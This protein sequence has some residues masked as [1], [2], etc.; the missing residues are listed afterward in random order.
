MVRVGDFCIDRYEAHTVEL[1]KDGTWT[2]HPHYLPV[3]DI[4]VM[5]KTARGVFPQGYINQ[6]QADRACLEAGKR[7]CT[8]DEWTK[9][10]MGPENLTFTYGK[11]E[12]PGKC[13][14]RKEHLL[15]T[16]HGIDEKKWTFQ[17]FN[18]PALTTMP[19]FL[20]RSGT[21]KLCVSGFGA[22]D[23]VGNLAEWTSDRVYSTADTVPLKEGFKSKHMTQAGNGIF[24]GSFYANSNENGPGCYYK[25]TAHE[26]TYHDYS[27]GFR[28]CVDAKK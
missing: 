6:V 23:M 3:N 26:P 12:E 14:T 13:N 21:M 18:D 20:E 28:C 16:L 17:D 24:M 15:S 8:S 1:K 11:T 5:A 7:L 9:A 2:L 22:Y 25:T 10:C 19:G 27:T 4:R